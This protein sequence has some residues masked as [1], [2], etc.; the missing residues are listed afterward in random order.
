MAYLYHTRMASNCGSIPGIILFVDGIQG[1]IT[2][3]E[4]ISLATIRVLLSAAVW[5]SLVVLEEVIEGHG[6]IHR[7]HIALRNGRGL[8]HAPL[9]RPLGGLIDEIA[10]P[11]ADCLIP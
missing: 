7:G 11:V 4:S 10:H 3:H 9:Y 8:S 5:F 2:T 6:C 1:L